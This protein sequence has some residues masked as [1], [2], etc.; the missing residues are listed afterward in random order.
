MALQLPSADLDWTALRNFAMLRGQLRVSL[1]PKCNEKCWFCHNEGDVPPPF[2]HLNRDARPREREM[3][4]GDFLNVLGGL[5]DA[6]LERVYFTGG[7]PLLSPLARPVL[8]QL[9][10]RG[11]DATYTLITNGTLVRRH[12]EWLSTTALD[13]VK[14]SL[15]YFSDE[16]LKAIASVRFGIATILDGIEAA[17]ETFERVE[18]NT[19]VQRENEH[20]LHD[21]LTYA[22]ERRLS[23]RAVHRAGGHRLQCRPEG[24]RDRRPGHHQPPAHPDQRRGGGGLRGRAGAPDLPDRRHRDRGHPS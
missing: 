15:H 10:D 22:L 3:T 17:R 11:P 23:V 24:L 5:V 6:G 13:K 7:E 1:T 12:Q 19:L 21:I 8:T 16:S 2:T 18:L 20:E 14:I 9:P 4:A